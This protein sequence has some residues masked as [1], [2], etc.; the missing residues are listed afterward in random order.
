MTTRR[1][2]HQIGRAGEYYVAAELN[3]RGF[4]AVTFTGNMPGIDIMASRVGEGHTVFIQVKTKR[5]GNWHTSHLEGDK[6][7]RK[8]FFWVFVALPEEQPGHPKYWIV[9]DCWIRAD[10]KKNH[11]Q[12]MISWKQKHGDQERRSTHHGIAESRLKK[13]QDCWD[14]LKMP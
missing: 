2:T 5:R 8:D 6:T 3:R 13:W 1:Q 11:S 7:P 14:L 10:I 12:Y 9:P 4:D